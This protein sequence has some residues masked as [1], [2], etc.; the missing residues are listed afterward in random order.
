MTSTAASYS[1]SAPSP[2][3]ARD[4]EAF[5]HFDAHRASPH[6]GAHISG[7]DLATALSESVVAE[8]ERALARFGV[9]FF[10]E[11]DLTPREHIALARRF[12]EIDVNRFFRSVEGIPEIAEVRKEPDQKANIGGGWHTDH[13]YDQI[14]AKASLLYAREVP[15]LGGDTVFASV[16][17]AFE[18]L[19]PGLRTTLESSESGPFKST[20]VR[21]RRQYR[22]GAGSTWTHPQPRTRDA[23]RNPSRGLP[24]PADWPQRH[25]CQPRVHVAFRRLDSAGIRGAARTS[26]QSDHACGIFVPLPVGRRVAR[27]LGQSHDM[28]SGGQRLFGRATAA[29]SHYR[30]RRCGELRR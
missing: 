23:G 20:C 10:R 18:S 12:G 21:S 14:P 3:A 13:S 6:V 15:D 17:A 9:L 29:A 22:C 5:R 1:A 19:S 2:I 28:A 11:Q 7:L 25:L 4:T 30:Q 27:H 8:L 16:E 26:L 24:T